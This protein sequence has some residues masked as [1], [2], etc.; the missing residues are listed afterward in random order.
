MALS[1]KKMFWRDPKKTAKKFSKIKKY[2]GFF[3]FL[4]SRGGKKNLKNEKIFW[5]F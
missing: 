3:D 1:R 4:A 2:F 5:F